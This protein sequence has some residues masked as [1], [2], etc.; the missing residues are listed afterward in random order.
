[1]RIGLFLFLCVLAVAGGLG[2]GAWEYQKD[3]RTPVRP[4][5]GP[6]LSAA[7]SRRYEIRWLP[8]GSSIPSGTRQPTPTREGSCIKPIAPLA[9]AS[10][11]R[12]TASWPRNSRNLRT[13]WPPNT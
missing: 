4:L 13:S 3:T 2:W 6:F 9:M 12:E 7:S 1:M 10:V 11:Q 8:P 5:P